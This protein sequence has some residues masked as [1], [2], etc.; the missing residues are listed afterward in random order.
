MSFAVP[1]HTFL[2]KNK[3]HGKA[4][5]LRLSFSFLGS[6]LFRLTLCR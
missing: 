3:A 6:V 2:G 1:A 5:E 4:E